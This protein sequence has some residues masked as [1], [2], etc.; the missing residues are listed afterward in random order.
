MGSCRNA[1]WRHPV[2]ACNW[3]GCVV[4]REIRADL[5]RPRG[6]KHRCL[7]PDAYLGQEHQITA[8]AI[9]DGRMSYDGATS[10]G[11]GLMAGA[12]SKIFNKTQIFTVVSSEGR[13]RVG[14]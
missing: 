10:S 14:V 8:L 3:R 4:S 2:G 7:A 11:C 6:A 1:I 9:L 12:R 13:R 5:R